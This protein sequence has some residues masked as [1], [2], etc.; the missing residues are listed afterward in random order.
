MLGCSL[1][2]CFS[3]SVVSAVS[4]NLFNYSDKK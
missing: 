2:D 1:G 3:T 4:L